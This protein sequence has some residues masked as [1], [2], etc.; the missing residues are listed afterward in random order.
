MKMATNVYEYAGGGKCVYMFNYTYAG[1]REIDLQMSKESRH[2]SRVMRTS[3]GT[4]IFLSFFL[5]FESSTLNL[6][7]LFESFFFCFEP[8]RH[9]LSMLN[10]KKDFA[11]PNFKQEERELR[12][13][14]EERPQTPDNSA[15]LGIKLRRTEH[16]QRSCRSCTKLF[17]NTT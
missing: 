13:E 15:T 4:V 17:V 10:K 2:M 16:S 8:T 6:Q 3:I 7:N 11:W 12:L 14:V 9:E 5:G 1:I